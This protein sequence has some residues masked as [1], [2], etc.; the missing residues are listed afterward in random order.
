MGFL[1]SVHLPT[2]QGSLRVCGEFP[3]PSADRSRAPGGVLYE[4]NYSSMELGLLCADVAAAGL[5]PEVP[6]APPSFHHVARGPFAGIAPN[7]LRFVVNSRADECR[8]LKKLRHCDYSL[9]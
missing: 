6:I 7:T 2:S 1:R 3:V 9:D 8:Q 4:D 5:N